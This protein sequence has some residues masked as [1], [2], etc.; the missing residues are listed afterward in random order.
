MRLQT[1]YQIIKNRQQTHYLLTDTEFHRP[2]TQI[3]DLTLLLRIL[4]KQIHHAAL[5]LAEGETMLM[6]AWI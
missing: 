2:T 5:L 1:I 3:T 4:L 6:S